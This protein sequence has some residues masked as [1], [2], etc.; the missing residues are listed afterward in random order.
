MAAISQQE[1]SD[2]K[3]G[4]GHLGTVIQRCGESDRD[5]IEIRKDCPEVER[6]SLPQ[7]YGS[8]ASGTAFDWKVCDA[9]WMELKRSLLCRTL[10]QAA[11]LYFRN[12]ISFDILKPRRSRA[13][14]RRGI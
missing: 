1:R 4:G 2:R 12:G 13:D 7:N 3:T 11:S 10:P 6:F 14:R 9:N 5:T 8:A